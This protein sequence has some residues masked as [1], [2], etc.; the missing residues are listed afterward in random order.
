MNIRAHLADP[1]THGRTLADGFSLL[2]RCY[3][4]SLLTGLGEIRSRFPSVYFPALAATEDRKP[5]AIHVLGSRDLGQFVQVSGLGGLSLVPVLRGLLEDVPQLDERRSLT[6][7]RLRVR[8]DTRED[9]H[10]HYLEAIF[11]NEGTERLCEDVN[12]VRR[13]LLRLGVDD[14][15][16]FTWS[17]LPL[18]MQLAVVEPDAS[19]G[20]VRD[21]GRAANRILQPPFDITM[22]A[23][24]LWLPELVSRS[25]GSPPA[26]SI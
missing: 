12:G 10:H 19:R 1:E 22:T 3:D 21:L 5:L 24:Q 15:P 23:A 13:S 16:D 14:A 20:L 26:A 11:D 25:D 4:N 18:H 17:H 6:V 2:R 8:D 7:M 9:D